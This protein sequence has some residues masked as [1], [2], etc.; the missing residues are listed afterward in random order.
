MSARYINDRKLPDKAIDVLD[1]VGASRMLLPES[2]RR[3]TVSVKDV[4]TVIAKM[5]RLPPKTVSRTDSLTIA[6]MS[7]NFG[8]GFNHIDIEKAKEL[9]ITVSNTPS[10]LT[11]CTADIAMSL[12]LMAA[13][14]VGE[15]ER[16]LR[17]NNWTGW[18]PT[19]LLG[20]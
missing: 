13:R 10:V 18:R 4:E 6:N 20:T 7:G 3:K 12:I 19:H 11:D 2:K 16:E 15:G 9:G 1:E 5:A 14:R 17:A 8:V